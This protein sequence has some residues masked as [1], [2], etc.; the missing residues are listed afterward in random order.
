MFEG[1]LC[2]KI[3]FGQKIFF[4]RKDLWPRKVLVEN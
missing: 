1:N 2:G 3:I 4:G